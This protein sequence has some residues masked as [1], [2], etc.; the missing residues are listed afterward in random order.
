MMS[1]IKVMIS[2][3]NVNPEVFPKEKNVDNVFYYFE[4]ILSLSTNSP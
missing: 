4:S 1:G 3:E 2:P